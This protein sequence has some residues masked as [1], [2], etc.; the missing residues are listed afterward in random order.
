MEFITTIYQ[1]KLLA[2]FSFIACFIIY[3]IIKWI[4]LPKRTIH[5][6]NK[7][8]LPEDY[9]K[10]IPNEIYSK[11]DLKNMKHYWYPVDIS[12][13]INDTKPHGIFLLDE[14]LVLYRSKDGKINCAQDLCPHRSARLSLGN[15]RDG[16]LECQYHGWQF[17]TD[18]KCEKVPAVSK[19]SKFAQDICLNT[20]P[21]VETMGLIWV[22]VGPKELAHESLIPKYIFREKGFVGWKF[23]EMTTD[24]ELRHDLMVDNLVDMAHLDFTHDGTLGKRSLATYVKYE[25]VTKDTLLEANP[26]TFSYNTKKPELNQKD[27]FGNDPKKFGSNMTF[28]PPCF[29]KI[30]T[31][32]E[33]GLFVQ[34]FAIIP[35]TKKTMR[36]IQ[37]FDNEIIPRPVMEFIFPTR[38]AQYFINRNAMQILNQDF[39]MLRGINDNT[40]LNAKEYSKIINA[41]IMIKRY[42]DWTKVAFE[43]DPW[44]KGFQV[45]DIED[46]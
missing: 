17:S 12:S 43:K 29:V 23:Y 13:N 38:I 45:K 19:E 26:E 33:S 34:T 2:C 44:F 7:D 11:I 37:S 24:L 3:Y 46:L 14:P 16:N 22:W 4:N 42:R 18:G 21:C 25:E 32:F 39:E 9:L 36:L 41:D 6:E 1:H 35:S 31:Q 15:M 40:E 20:K 27:V 30:R 8:N 28:I 10:N 5:K